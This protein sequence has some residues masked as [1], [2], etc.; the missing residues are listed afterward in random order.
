VVPY[1]LW[2]H[3]NSISINT[4]FNKK[5]ALSNCTLEVSSATSLDGIIGYASRINKKR[6]FLFVSK[7]LGKHIP[8]SP[9]KMLNSHKQL[10][11][12]IN[13]SIA[14]ENILVIGL[15]ETATGL[16]WG[17]FE[18][19][20]AAS[21]YYIHTTRIRLKQKQ[22]IQFEESHSHATEQYLY[23]PKDKQFNK[24]LI[25]HI[26][27]ID[28]EITTGNTIKN[29]I[30]TIK[31][32]F[33]NCK[34]S[35]L[36]LLNWKNY[37]KPYT[38]YALKEGV[39][40][41]KEVKIASKNNIEETAISTKHEV[42]K[43][44]PN[45]LSNGYGRVGALTFPAISKAHIKLVK[46]IK[47]K[48]IL[49][50]GTGEFMHYPFAISKYFDKSNTLKIQSTTRS[51]VAIGGVIKSKLTFRDNYYPDV[52]NYLYNVIDKSYDV[53]FVFYES[54]TKFDGLLINAL[55]TKFKQV[56]PI[57]I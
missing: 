23:A 55:K 39:F 48:S 53:V 6:S 36:T 37:K 15:A 31:E 57:Y 5:V 4:M 29:L 24:K 30:A 22:L 13:P 7:V 11:K 50:L 19:L 16:G 52:N 10:A 20:K 43:I 18:A 33:P 27:I 21:K 2:Q 35:V 40:K 25:Q 17:V 56:I 26:V 42:K 12:L 38:I 1:F 54:N 49:L 41:A 51:P 47:N 9:Q 44:L 45:H 34:F 3:Y 46:N 28:D 14:T 32:Q 8:V